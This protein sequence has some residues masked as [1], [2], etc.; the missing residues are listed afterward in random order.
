[1]TVESRPFKQVDVHAK[2]SGY[3]R[4]IF[5]DVGDKVS[6]GQELAILEVP[7][8]NAQVMGAQADIRRSQDAIRRAQSEIE[9]AEST[10]HAYHSAYTR[11]K[12]A[13]EERPGLVAEQEL[14]DAMAQ[15]ALARLSA[16]QA[17]SHITAPFA[18]VVTKRYV[19]TGALISA[20]TS[21]ETQSQPVVQLAEWSLLRLVIPVPASSVPLLHLGSVV[22]VHVL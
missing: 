21:S 10:H 13:S 20:G 14:D 15:A 1:L 12:Q 6:A 3:I 2:V 17:Y 16:L 4:H 19:D 8:L 7:E 11:L 22:Q 18:G 9:R 5:V